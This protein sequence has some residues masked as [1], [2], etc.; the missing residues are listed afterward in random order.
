MGKANALR[1]NYIHQLFIEVNEVHATDLLEEALCKQLKSYTINVA[2][3]IQ[4]FKKKH[5]TRSQ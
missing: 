4:D 5:T 3:T 2:S 1:E